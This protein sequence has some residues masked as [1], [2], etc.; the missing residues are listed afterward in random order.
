MKYSTIETLTV[1]QYQHLYR[2]HRSGSDETDKTIESV[3]VLT[4]LPEN[5]VEE[6]LIPDFN[7]VGIE[8]ARVFSSELKAE[9]KTFIDISGKRY[10]INYLPHT[11]TAGQY[12][13]IQTWMQRG[14]IENLHLIFASLVYEVIGW[15]IF[16]KRLKYNAANHPVISE[17]I[18][19]CRF[20]DVYSSCVFFLK[21]WNASI[22]SLSGYLVKEAMKKGM[23]RKE[24]Q[25]ILKKISD[26]FTV[27]KKSQILK[28]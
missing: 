7:R 23:S 24:M 5:K 26:G 3:S 17:K 18:L 25:E 12:V 10:G 19:D 21:L 9:P 13:E 15:G 11:L 22:K 28:T 1:G 16:K 4:G 20:I 14:V 27:P 6:M 8:L 2:I